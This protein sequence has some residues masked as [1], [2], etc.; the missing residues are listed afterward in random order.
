MKSPEKTYLYRN[1]NGFL[2]LSESGNEDYLYNSMK[3]FIGTIKMFW[4]VIMVNV[5]QLS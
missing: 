4:D 2:K 5:A 3:D 1:I